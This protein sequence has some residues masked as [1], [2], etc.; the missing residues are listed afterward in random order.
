MAKLKYT[1]VRVR[2]AQESIHCLNEAVSHV[3]LFRGLRVLRTKSEEARAPRLLPAFGS[4]SQVLFPSL[5]LFLHGNLNDADV[6][7]Q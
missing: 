2:L 7:N 4:V 6:R 1:Q 3:S 5:S